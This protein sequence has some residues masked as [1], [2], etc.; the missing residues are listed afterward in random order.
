MIS[1]Q[2]TSEN[3]FV[4]KGK[5]MERKKRKPGCASAKSDEERIRSDIDQFYANAKE[6]KKTADNA[7]V[8]ELAEQYCEDTKYFLKKKDYVT[9]FGAINYA[10][11]LIDA[12]RKSSKE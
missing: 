11:G 6:V 2:I 1:Q 5:E 7:Y 4:A 9:A 3:E 12:F 10:H 8:L